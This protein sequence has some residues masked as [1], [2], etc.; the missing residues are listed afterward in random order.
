MFDNY[1]I[2]RGDE[3]MYLCVDLKSFY[4][5]CE[6]VARGL[7]PFKV[8][9][10]ETENIIESQRIVKEEYEIEK[11]K[12]ACEITDKGFEF[13]IKNIKKGTINIVPFSYFN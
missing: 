4:A 11:I 6:C 10:V 8:N 9:L 1:N 7:D 13:I 2:S 12:K 3:Q 5:S